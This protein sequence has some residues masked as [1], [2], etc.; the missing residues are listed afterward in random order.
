M[1]FRNVRTDFNG[2]LLLSQCYIA[3][4]TY[5]EEVRC[6]AGGHPNSTLIRAETRLQLLHHRERP[7]RF[8]AK[9]FRTIR[10]DFNGV[11]ACLKSYIASATRDEEGRCGAGGHPKS[12]LIR[13]DT[14]L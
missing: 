2:P 1:S 7:L 14:S 10:T 11:F 5:D 8:D 13:T 4:A 3:V 12:R 6:G 9:S